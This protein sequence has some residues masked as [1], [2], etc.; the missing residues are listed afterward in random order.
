[1]RHGALPR[2]HERV[3]ERVDEELYGVG[4]L[5]RVGEIAERERV[6]ERGPREGSVGHDET[7]EITG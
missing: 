5:R 7:S 2:V 3:A 6:T 1:V 4:T